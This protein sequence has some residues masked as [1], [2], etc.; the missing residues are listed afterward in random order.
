[1]ILAPLFMQYQM[2]S[3]ASLLMPYP[4]ASMNL[5]A[6]SL[7]CGKQGRQASRHGGAHELAGKQ[8]D[9]RQGDARQLVRHD[10][11]YLH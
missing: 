4:L 5:Q 1:M 11:T 3:T 9:L 2:H 10:G 8:A 7:T 6:S